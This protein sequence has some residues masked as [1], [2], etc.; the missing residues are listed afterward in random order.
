MT[1]RPALFTLALLLCAVPSLAAPAVKV[2]QG[3]AD[4]PEAFRSFGLKGDLLASGDGFVVLVGGSSRPLAGPYGLPLSDPY[5]LIMA[6]V[7]EG[8]GGRALTLIGA[9]S[10]RI[11]G[12]AVAATTASVRVAGGDIVV[13]AT[14]K[15][16]GGSPVEIESRFEIDFRRGCVRIVSEVRN[17]GP[18]ELAGV[19]FSVGAN[20]VQSYTFSPFNAAA[21]P[22]LNFRVYQ[23][24]DHFLAWW[25]P[26]PLE[27]SDKPLPGRLGPGRSH[28]VAYELRAGTDVL[29]LLDGLYKTARVPAIRQPIDFRAVGWTAASPKPLPDF[30]GPVEVVVREPATGAIFFRT[31]LDKPAGI[32]I[33]LPDGTYA[34]R[35]NFFPLT[36]EKTF[37]LAAGNGKSPDL[38]AV[39]IPPLG[40]MKLRL[41]D[42]SGS[43]VPGKVSFLGLA[44]VESPYFAP[45]NPVLT[46]RGILAARNTIWPGRGDLDLVLP[47]GTYLAAAAHGPEYTRETRTIEVLAGEN[48]DLNFTVERAFATPGLVSLD[49]HM[50]TLYSDG[51]LTIADRLRS[52]V[53]EGIDVAVAAD[54]NFVTDYAPELERI[55]LRNE[56]AVI[57][58]AEISARGGTI[59]FNT[60][61]VVRRP[62][63][64]A[65]GAIS[66]ANDTPAVLFKLA[67]E[68]NPGSIVQVNHPR[69][70]GLGYFLTYKL[71]P[72]AAAFA[73]APF[74]M[75]FD[76]MEAMNGA[77]R[78]PANQA[79]V[80]DWFRFLNMGYPIKVVG[81]SDAHGY[82]GDETGYSRTFV[83]YPGPEGPA[84]D[85]AALVK[86]VKEGRS[87]VSNGPVVA[88]KA[89]RKASFG[90]T[91]TAK[92]GKLDLD[93]TVTGAPWLDVAEVRIIVNGERKE[94][95]AA[96]GR[97]EEGVGTLKLERRVR[98]AIDR[99]AWVVVEV[100]GRKSMFPS[101]QQR[102]G[103]G[104]ADGSAVAYALT[105]PIFVDVNGDGR[106]DPVRP[107]KIA[108][109]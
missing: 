102:S 72:E 84:L 53:A 24:P 49:P 92:G 83:L 23:R 40:T 73:N 32:S 107:E 109:K 1:R 71:D 25:N 99:D 12:K 38:W 91:V 8:R 70:S 46:G 13:A 59:H 95:L 30:P 54:H 105:N 96:G 97:G 36:R 9:P 31:Y 48:P 90:D 94:T 39:D 85:Q 41:R 68:K 88:V 57:A 75:G 56:L 63:E 81:S 103:N 34:V 35:A 77:R 108:I 19:S 66:I 5:G 26:N 78:G 87:F 51:Q 16:Q 69:S 29:A 4:L 15:D 61:P 86:A 100:V 10:L 21:F 6:F 44:P 3:P 52:L 82:D 76:V 22:G 37:R 79:V 20:F 27:T 58:G 60:Y 14:A 43:P 28:R 17:A 33:P 2:V 18:A 89:G 74:D 11:A 50:H 64:P 106:I 47:A 98:L 67:R 55:G 93:V 42:R 62:D 101:L 45:E 65:R 80:S 104:T 7:P